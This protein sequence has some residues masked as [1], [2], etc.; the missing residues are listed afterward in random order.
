MAPRDSLGPRRAGGARAPFGEATNA[1]MKMRVSSFG[2][3]IAKIAY[4]WQF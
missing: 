1:P 3:E 4:K 2:D